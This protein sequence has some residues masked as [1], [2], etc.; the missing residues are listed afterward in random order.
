MRNA[1]LVARRI[2]RGY[3]IQGRGFYVWDEDPCEAL[4]WG[5]ALGDTA[6]AARARDAEE[7]TPDDELRR[8]G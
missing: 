1:E 6:A 5:V 7:P 2:G 4:A 3:A 8:S